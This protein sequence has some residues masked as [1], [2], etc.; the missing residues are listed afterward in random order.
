MRS[1]G[2][3][4]YDVHSSTGAVLFHT[5]HSLAAFW[6]GLKVLAGDVYEARLEMDN[7]IGVLQYLDFLPG[8]VLLLYFITNS[9]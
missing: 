2:N 6:P 3:F 4:Y 8:A 9:R 7:F 5:M 1:R